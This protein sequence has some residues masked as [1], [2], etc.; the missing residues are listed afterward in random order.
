MHHS[1]CMH[2]NTITTQGR[3]HP[4]CCVLSILDADN[5][6]K[7]HTDCTTQVRDIPTSAHPQECTYEWYATIQIL[8]WV[9]CNETIFHDF[10]AFFAT[11]ASNV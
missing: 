3:H 4:L 6:M 1:I 7:S 5:N 2:T 11:L 10:P 9:A 8:L